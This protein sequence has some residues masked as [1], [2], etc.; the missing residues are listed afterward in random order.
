MGESGAYKKSNLIKNYGKPQGKCGILIS[1]LRKKD[2]KA[3][4]KKC[5]SKAGLE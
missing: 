1:L 5:K 4:K 2:M 3:K